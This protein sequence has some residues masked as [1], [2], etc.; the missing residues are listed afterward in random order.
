V[1]GVFMAL[2]TPSSFLI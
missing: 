1:M 2:V